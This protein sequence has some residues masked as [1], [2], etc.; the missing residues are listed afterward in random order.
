L[1]ALIGYQLVYHF[2]IQQ[3]KAEMKEKI[4]RIKGHK[5]VLAFRFSAAE[6]ASLEKEGESEVTIKGEMFDILEK[7]ETGGEVIIR[8]ISDT[9]ETALVQALQKVAQKNSSD[10]KTSDTLFKLMSASFCQPALPFLFDP[11][12]DP[13]EHNSCYLSFFTSAIKQILTPP[14][15]IA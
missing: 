5:D 2:R 14:P 15:R 8:C 9:M 4:A 6:Y 13:Q 11:I 12:A 7:I 10:K 1:F 3:A